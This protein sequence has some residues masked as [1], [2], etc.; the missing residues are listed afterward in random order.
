VANRSL[1]RTPR[2]ISEERSLT[3]EA[4][5]RLGYSLS[6]LKYPTDGDLKAL[7][8]VTALRE[9][10][11][12]R[13]HRD[14]DARRAEVASLKAQLRT[15]P[16][17]PAASARVDLPGDDKRIEREITRTRLKVETFIANEL[18]RQHQSDADA[19]GRRGCDLSA[20]HRTRARLA[21]SA[22]T[23]G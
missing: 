11:R 5:G 2:A 1:S 4:L 13:L 3:R 15:P 18:R 10:A 22:S 16:A 6:D 21:L 23:S 14:V 19:E 7:T 8:P 17:A 9:L 12:E 20:S